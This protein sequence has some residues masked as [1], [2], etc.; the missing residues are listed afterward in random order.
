[1][2]W[3]WQRR[4]QRQATVDTVETPSPVPGSIAAVQRAPTT[5]GRLGQPRQL[6]SEA[7]LLARDYL[8]AAGGRVRVEDEDVLSATLLDGS[9]VRY[10][11]T[12]AKARGDESMTL[13]VEGSAALTTILK[14][15]ATR[16][17]LTA[18]RLTPTADP[19][20]LALERCAGPVAKCGRC[21]K[22]VDTS[23]TAP[24][25]RC[26]TCPLREGRIVLR[27]RTPG[28]LSARMVRQEQSDAVE[29][30]YLMVARDHQGR[31]DEWLRHAVDVAT[32]HPIPV[33]TEIALASAQPTNIP[34]RCEHLL[35]AACA[36]AERT[37]GE[38][39]AATGIFLRQRS[40]DEYRRRLEE[41]AVTFERLER[42]SPETA[43]AAKV[44]RS[45]ELSAL[46]EVYAVDVE[47]Q[48]ESACFIGSPQAIVA[49]RPQKADGELLLRVD[50]GRQHVIPPDCVTCG[51]SVHTG[52]VCDAGHVICS[53]C[54]AACEQCGAWRCAT[55]GEE[56]LANCANCGQPMHKPT[57]SSADVGA[58]P[59]D[60]VFTVRH[61]E[62]LPPEMW[63]AA[64][65][66]LLV[67]KGITVESRRIAGEV[68]IWQGNSVTGKMMIAALRPQGHWALR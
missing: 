45:R 55:C 1:M 48:L 20:A 61:L 43:R 54:A 56:P 50:V 30:V 6:T 5:S 3:F 8:Q 19:V 58:A 16:S 51:A 38:P 17:R 11:T 46:S 34:S 27:W 14:D 4:R 40:L 36:A 42:E 53:R 25:D 60:G 57:T 2:R 65:E 41:V 7:L 52:Y 49:L 39:L 9:L 32:G 13:L 64:I 22:S 31:R 68:A 33:L 12:L 66:W 47:A 63:L 21:L 24:I 59:A 37:L 15:I 23:D 67:C 44:G 10:T 35:A 62:A 28:R 26:E 29:L 18:L